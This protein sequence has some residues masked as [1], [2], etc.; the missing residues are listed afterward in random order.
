[1][2]GEEFNKWSFQFVQR[3]FGLSNTLLTPSTIESRLSA[4]SPQ[5]SF[6]VLYFGAILTASFTSPSATRIVAVAVISLPS[7][8]TLPFTFTTSPTFSKSD[9][10]MLS[11]VTGY[12]PYDVPSGRIPANVEGKVGTSPFTVALV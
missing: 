8:S 12:A 5:L 10:L 2:V 9:S 11:H 4:G 1:M 3:I 7:T 6:K